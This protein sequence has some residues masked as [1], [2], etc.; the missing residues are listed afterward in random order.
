MK[1]ISAAIRAG[2][3]K[4]LL[5][6][7]IATAIG[8]VPATAAPITV[9]NAS[10][11]ILPPG[12]LDQSAGCLGGGPSPCYSVGPIP[13][14]TNSGFSGQFEPGAPGP[15]NPYFNTLPSGDITAWTSD[16]LILQVVG[17]TVTDGVSYTLDV[18]IGNRKDLPFAG[19]IA[20]V[21]GG[22][23]V[24]P[25]VG[26]APG[27]GEWATY[28]ATYLGT[29]ATAGQSIAIRLFTSGTQG[30]FDNVRLYDN[31]SAAPI[32]EPASLALLGVG[33]LG[34]A[35]ARRRLAGR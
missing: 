24:V 7:V 4:A 17:T 13:D 22:S 26:I 16:N 18:D 32:P 20:L 33:L 34:L 14:W 2:A 11:E 23:L 28:T 25:G 5:G 21:I 31:T 29:A 9:A 19:A 27:E 10:F 3:T 12:G 6:A 1:S 8:A 30:N 15:A 35:V